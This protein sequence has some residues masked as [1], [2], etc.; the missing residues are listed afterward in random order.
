V[1][2]SPTTV[3]GADGVMWQQWRWQ[4]TQWPAL[5]AEASMPGPTE[6]LPYL[7]VSTFASWQAAAQW[8]ARLV[9]DALP[10]HGLDAVVRQTALRLT[11]GLADDETKVRAVHAYV[12]RQI[13]YVGLEF[14]IH[15]LK[16]HGVREILDRRFG[17]CKDKA[18]L[19]VALLREVGIDA[20]VVQG[21]A[22]VLRVTT[23]QGR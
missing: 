7:H 3:K 20:Q 23:I 11:R 14:G 16:P 21:D 15:S 4:G 19:L 17:D 8:Y 18:T 10:Q 2:P 5:R 9:A 1:L 6:V 12:A 13:R 22:A